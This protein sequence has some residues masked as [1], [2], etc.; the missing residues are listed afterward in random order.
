MKGLKV[1]GGTHDDTEIVDVLFNSVLSRLDRE[2]REYEDVLISL[3]TGYAADPRVRA[4]AKQALSERAG[5]YASELYAAVAQ[6]YSDDE[7]LQQ[8]VLASACPL[9]VSL[10]IGGISTDPLLSRGR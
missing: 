9:P 6:T 3:I 7:E 8:K 5:W 4:L 1:L 2:S 10:R